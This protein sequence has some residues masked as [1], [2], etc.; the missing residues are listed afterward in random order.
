M[1]RDCSSADVLDASEK[2][3]VEVNWFEDR[4]VEGDSPVA[5]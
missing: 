5:G 1:G 2:I 4:T 3:L